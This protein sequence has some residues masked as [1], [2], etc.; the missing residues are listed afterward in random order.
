MNRKAAEIG[1]PY[2]KLICKEDSGTN[3]DLSREPVGKLMYKEV[4]AL[5]RVYLIGTQTTTD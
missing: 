4:V 2:L 5:R 1:G 3:S